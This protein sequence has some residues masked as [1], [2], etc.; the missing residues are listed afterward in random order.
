[1]SEL[2]GI[3]GRKLLGKDARR[4]YCSKECAQEAT[5][6]R[7]RN[8]KRACRTANKREWAL[9][10]A[11]ELKKLSDGCG[12]DCLATYVYNNYKRR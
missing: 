5:L 2:C 1:M 10:E 9:K 4:K 11:L 6:S 12:V 3:C 7:E 8:R